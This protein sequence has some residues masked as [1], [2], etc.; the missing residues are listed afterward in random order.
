MYLYRKRQQRLR[1]EA[2]DFHPLRL[3]SK[4]RD[5]RMQLLSL[6]EEGHT[7]ESKGTSPRGGLDRL[8]VFTLQRP[9]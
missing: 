4:Y 5:L 6:A 2:L 1:D 9:A 3:G 7:N 8:I